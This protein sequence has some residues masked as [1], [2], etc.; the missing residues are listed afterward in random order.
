MHVACQQTSDSGVN[1]LS[2][3]V[4]LLNKLYCFVLHFGYIIK[5]ILTLSG[6]QNI[7]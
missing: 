5:Y 4:V 2:L 6:S 1:E 7:Y 3:F